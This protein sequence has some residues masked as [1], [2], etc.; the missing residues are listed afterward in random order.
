MGDS[1]H[2]KGIQKDPAAE[3]HVLFFLGHKKVATVTSKQTVAS[4]YLGLI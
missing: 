2:V 4:R 3:P 1:W